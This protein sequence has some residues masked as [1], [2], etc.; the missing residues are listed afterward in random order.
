M[1][2]FSFFFLN[3]L[4]ILSFSACRNFQQGNQSAE[5]NSPSNQANSTI[6]YANGFDIVYKE[7]LK[8][9]TVFEPGNNRR[10][11]ETYYILN[12]EEILDTVEPKN[13]FLLPLDSIAVFSATQLNAL[14]KLGLLDKVIGVS[15]ANY[16]RN[17]HVQERYQQGL[18][19]ELAGNGSFYIE[20]TLQ[21]NPSVIFY[22]P[23]N[24]SESHPLAATKI[25]MV[26]YLDFMEDNP[27]GRAE[28]IKFTAV[29]FGKERLA[30]SLFNIIENQYNEYKEIASKASTKPSVFSDKYFNGQ[31]FVPGG[32]SYVAKLFADANA[33]YIWKEN[34][35]SGSFPLDFEVVYN[36]A[37]NADFWRIIGSYNEKPGY[38]NLAEE[39]ELYTH[40]K[41]FQEH[42]VIYC[43]AEK[44]AYFENSPLEPQVV[45]AD[46]IKAFHPELLPGYQPVYYKVIP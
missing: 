18:I 44:T 4:L 12:E 41:A 10:V 26:S 19:T 15:E 27:L 25:P 43:D 29:F 22:S 46:L 30:D 40:F 34:Q 21:V 9:V 2:I 11:K 33:D 28:W 36:E 13:Q 24:T 31:W 3:I 45:L 38:E 20:K 37:G 42:H 7:N 35:Q 5:Q 39:N 32:Q 17:E 16:I 8:I 14:D 23:Y 6:K 1:K